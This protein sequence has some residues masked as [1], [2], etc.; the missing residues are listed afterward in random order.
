MKGGLDA[1][2]E[3]RTQNS[4]RNFSLDVAAAEFDM[5]LWR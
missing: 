4:Q 5:N 3:L 1:V 2:P